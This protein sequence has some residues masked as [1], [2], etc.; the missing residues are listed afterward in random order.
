MCD[1][2]SSPSFCYVF[3]FYD[4]MYAHIS[5]LLRHAAYCKICI[6]FKLYITTVCAVNQHGSRSLQTSQSS[7]A[8]RRAVT[9]AAVCAFIY[10]L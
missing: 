5:G 4:T 6:K 8:A 2:K 1:S 3:L 10:S 7:S 9:R